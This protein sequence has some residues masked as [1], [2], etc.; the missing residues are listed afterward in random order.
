MR[1]LVGRSEIRSSCTC[2]D[3]LMSRPSGYC[4]S[5]WTTLDVNFIHVKI[6]VR[7]GCIR[8]LQHFGC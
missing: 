7:A 3:G 2:C 8:V 4:S 6:Y 1:V 5:K